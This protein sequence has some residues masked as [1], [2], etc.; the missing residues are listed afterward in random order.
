M[1]HRDL[2]RQ[3]SADRRTGRGLLLST[4]LT[5]GALGLSGCSVV[6]GASSPSAGSDKPSRSSDTSTASTPTPTPDPVSVASFT[7][8]VARRASDIPVDKVLRLRAQRGT[9][10]AVSVTSGRRNRPLKG[11]IEQQ[12][13]RWVATDR[14]EPG[15]RYQVRTVTVDADGL[16]ATRRTSFRTQ[17]LTLDEQTFPGFTPLGGQTVGVG[18]PAIVRFD[19]PVT[20]RASIE[21][22]LSV[23]S[24]PRQA[25]S[26]HW[27]N[28]NEVHWRPRH[29]WRPGTTV[30]V[31]ADI[32]SVPAGNGIYGQLSRTQTFT[33]GDSVIHRVNL[34]TDQMRSFVNGALVRTTPI[35]GG[36][37]GFA[38]RSGTKVI[39]E[40][41]RKLDMDAGTVNISQD[42]PEYYDLHGV[43]YAM[44]VT[45]TGEFLH[46][47]P[48]SV[49]SQGVANVSHGCVGMS[50]SNAAAIF[51]MSK[52]GDVVQVTGSN[53]PMTLDNGFGDW[54]ASFAAYRQGSAL[55]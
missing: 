39:V 55:R 3:R 42:S 40:K 16:R 15:R 24:S 30:T 51:N 47:A 1:F 48:W 31:T 54:N 52:P 21:R 19:V 5:M 43:E 49:A 46:A 11:A 50:T 14:L 29:F 34:R 7:S 4:A 41:F 38:T 35:T 45:Y 28:D 23:T 27:V 22:H 10:E 18:M 33:I 36:K 17:S 6:D 20:D 13:G 25:G 12:G 8:N 9:F 53:R 2:S 32:N 37:A 44:R 26:W